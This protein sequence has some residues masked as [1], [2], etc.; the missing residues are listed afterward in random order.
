MPYSLS[1]EMR[2]EFYYLK[3]G[4][5]TIIEYE[6]CSHT[7]SRYSYANTAIKFEKIQK[8]VNRLDVSLQLDMTQTVVYRALFW[9]IVGH[10]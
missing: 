1:D 9:G 7:L 5:I 3:Q 8:F 2:D 6:E 4:F 10:A